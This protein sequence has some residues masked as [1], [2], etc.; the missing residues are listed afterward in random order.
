MSVAIKATFWVVSFG[1][2]GYALFKLVKPNDEL[3]KQVII[4]FCTSLC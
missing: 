1:T 4:E 2:L 3:L